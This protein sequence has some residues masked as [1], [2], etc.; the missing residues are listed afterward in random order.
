MLGGRRSLFP[1]PD[2]MPASI[3]V[4]ESPASEWLSLA[5]KLD[6]QTLEYT[7]LCMSSQLS[8]ASENY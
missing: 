1:N 7:V 3:R 8:K 6:E 2:D 4:W 5:E